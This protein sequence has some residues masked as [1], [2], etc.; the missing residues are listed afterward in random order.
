MIA[1]LKKTLGA[2]Y[3][4][5]GETA[6]GEKLYSALI[7]TDAVDLEGDVIMPD[8]MDASYFLTFR[9]VYWGHDYFM[10]QSSIGRMVNLRR[11]KEGIE[12]DFTLARRP[13]DYKGEFPADLVRALIDQ[14]IVNGVSVGLDVKEKRGPSQKDRDR[15]GDDVNRIISKWKLLEFS[16]TPAPMNPTAV[17]R[18]MKSGALSPAQVKALGVDVDKMDA[19]KKRRSI[20]IVVPPPA[21]PKRKAA[22]VKRLVRESVRVE[23]ARARGKLYV[24]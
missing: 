17:M 13:D 11:T 24:E 22:N 14:K 20:V 2:R 19:P 9:T 5:K 12:A 16:V 23:L 8:G 18:A 10:P 7:T 4:S 3:A 1:T 6:D 15:Y 21:T